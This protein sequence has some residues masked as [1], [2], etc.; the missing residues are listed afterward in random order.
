MFAHISLSVCSIVYWLAEFVNGLKKMVRERV[1][2]GR[3]EREREKVIVLKKTRL[4][5]LW[6]F[7]LFVFNQNAIV[8][9]LSKES[10]VFFRG[11]LVSF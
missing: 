3:R 11:G 5:N 8:K 2:F 4:L 1:F 10:I 9:I 6:S 7:F